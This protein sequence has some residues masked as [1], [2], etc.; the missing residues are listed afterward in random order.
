MPVDL[1]RFAFALFH[2]PW[3]RALILVQW[4]HPLML[5][6]VPPDE[7]AR[8]VPVETAEER[9]ARYE[10]IA[11]DV[12]AVAFDE[13]EPPLFDGADG[14]ARTATV[15]L[16]LTRH[17]SGWNLDVDTGRNRGS[18]VGDIGAGR[19]WCLGQI[20]LDYD[21]RA[22]TPEGWTGPD[23]IADRRKCLRRVLH[24]ARESF[25]ACRALPVE[26]RLA[27]YTR[28]SCSNETGRRLSRPRVALGLRLFA[29]DAAPPEATW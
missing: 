5:W 24:M 25:R 27:V 11:A 14:R 16:G 20:L 4:L 28:G 22:R 9:S 2:A 1:L 12:V 6:A 8:A 19:S 10:S 29:L 3:L 23:L 18:L 17:E 13:A 15:L 7:V 26:E 21:G